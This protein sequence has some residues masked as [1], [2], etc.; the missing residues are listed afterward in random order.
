MTVLGHESDE[1]CCQEQH[2]PG[3]L[4]RDVGSKSRCDRGADRTDKK[5]RA[6]PCSSDQRLPFPQNRKG[7]GEPK[8]RE[9]DA[10]DPQ[11]GDRDN[12]QDE[13]R[14]NP[15][16]EVSECAALTPHIGTH[17]PVLAANGVA[18]PP[19]RRSRCAYSASA[20]A[21]AARSKSGQ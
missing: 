3:D 18:T 11:H 19:K 6:L 15:R 16:P 7:G 13:R 14:N 8:Q 21:R 2:K 5:S 10:P 4:K 1:Q 9:R 20:P 12:A 17:E